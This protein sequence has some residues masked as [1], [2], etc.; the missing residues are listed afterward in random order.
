MSQRALEGHRLKQSHMQSLYESV[1]GSEL[2]LCSEE[3]ASVACLRRPDGILS[4]DF[5]DY[6]R[7]RITALPAR[8]RVNRGKAGPVRCRACET[9]RL[10]ILYK[11][12]YE[13]I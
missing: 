7:I 11:G 4:S 1:D 9:R 12:T 13:L 8:K 3:A 6:A 10:P 2:K 5:K